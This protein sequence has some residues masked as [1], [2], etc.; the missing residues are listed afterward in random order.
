[1]K[2]RL[3]I[4]IWTGGYL[5]FQLVPIEGNVL[6]DSIDLEIRLFEGPQAR[7]NKVVINGNDRL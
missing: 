4:Y 3:P 7:I 6:N 1:M 2:M 5:F